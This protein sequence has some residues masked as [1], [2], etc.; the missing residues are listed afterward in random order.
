MN[1]AD[2]GARKILAANVSTFTASSRLRRDDV[3][4][5]HAVVNELAQCFVDADIVIDATRIRWR[6]ARRGTAAMIDLLRANGTWL[7]PLISAVALCVAAAGTWVTYIFFHRKTMQVTWIDSYRTLYAEFWKEENNAI[8]R[9]LITSDI[10]YAGI[11][12]VLIKRLKSDNND[13]SDSENEVLERIDKFCALLVR[14]QFFESLK[15]SQKQRDL[16]NKTYGDF[17]IIKIRKREALRDYIVKFWPGVELETVLKKRRPA[18]LGL[19]LQ[20]PEKW[21]FWKR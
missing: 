1:D 15:P 19:R 21:R 9:N 8:V 16:W 13:L 3:G 14:I 12:R 17:W 10:A 2:R 6:T 5:V 7:G 11:E 4:P 18:L 20:W